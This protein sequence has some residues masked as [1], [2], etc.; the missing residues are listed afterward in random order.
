MVLRIRLNQSGA[1]GGTPGRFDLSE[2]RIAGRSIQTISLGDID[3]DADL[4]ALLNVSSRRGYAPQL[5]LNDGRSEFSR[6]TQDLSIRDMQAYS[7]GD[8]DNDGDLDIFAGSFDQGYRI[9][10]NDGLGNYTRQDETEN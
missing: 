6:H 2:Q 8:L 5:W 4:D 3:G 9:W 1:Q 10:S 7:L